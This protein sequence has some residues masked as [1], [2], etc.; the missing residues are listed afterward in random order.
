MIKLINYLFFNWAKSKI[1]SVLT[2]F[3]YW[4]G[5]VFKRDMWFFREC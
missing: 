3:D 2:E 4:A 5:L 1:K